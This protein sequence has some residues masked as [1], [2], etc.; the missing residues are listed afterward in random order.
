MFHF[1]S[2][3]ELIRWAC[4]LIKSYFCSFKPR[5]LSFT[6]VK[7][8]KAPFWENW[9]NFFY[10]FF[11]SFLCQFTPISLFYYECR[12][13]LCLN[14]SFWSFFITPRRKNG[15]Y[16]KQFFPFYKTDRN[17]L[18]FILNNRLTLFFLKIWSEYSVLLALELAIPFIRL[19]FVC[20]HLQFSIT[21]IT[22]HIV[23]WSWK[24]TCRLIR[25]WQ[26]FLVV[27]INLCKTTC[28]T[29]K[30]MLVWRGEK[31]KKSLWLFF[32]LAN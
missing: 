2:N 26:T 13:C 22:V 7:G 20:H 27:I 12:I 31:R 19:F 17:I 16:Y 4:R 8:S 3:F 11:F 21:I 5:K 14:L 28:W 10:C 29:I 30:L 32:F 6:R 1:W 15:D 18:S 24:L 9:E 23:Q 25:Q